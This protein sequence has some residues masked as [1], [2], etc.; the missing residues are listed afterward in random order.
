MRLLGNVAQGRGSTI[1]L[2]TVNNILSL[3]HS[4]PPLSLTRSRG[5][6]MTELVLWFY[7]L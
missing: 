5:S 7:V 2:D 4:P 6:V 3:T 1:P